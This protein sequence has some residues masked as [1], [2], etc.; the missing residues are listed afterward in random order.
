M[1]RYSGDL[2]HLIAPSLDKDYTVA[3]ALFE[4][5]EATR[6]AVAS[7]IIECIH[8]IHLNGSL[9]RDVKLENFLYE[10]SEGAIKVVV[11]DFGQTKVVTEFFS[12]ATTREVGTPYTEAPEIRKVPHGPH[13]RYNPACDV[14]S[15]GVCLIGCL[16]RAHPA[17]F[18]SGDAPYNNVPWLQNPTDGQRC[19]Q[20]LA[21]RCLDLDASARPS[22]TECIAIIHTILGIVDHHAKIQGVLNNRIELGA[23]NCVSRTEELHRIGIPV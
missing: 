3:H 2:V 5:D 20:E 11:G 22:M 1:K 8:F 19:V 12:S 17:Q 4:S 7:G 16:L 13:W 21:K 9:H 23:V 14:Y 18:C 6:I 10:Y 15:V